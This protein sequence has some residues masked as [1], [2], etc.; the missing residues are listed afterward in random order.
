M[1]KTQGANFVPVF[2]SQML[3]LKAF[4]NNGNSGSIRHK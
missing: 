2:T 3:I 4:A 1:L